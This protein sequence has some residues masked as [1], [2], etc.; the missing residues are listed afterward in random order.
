MNLYDVVS[1]NLSFILNDDETVSDF[2]R[3][4]NSEKSKKISYKEGDQKDTILFKEDKDSIPSMLLDVKSN[5]TILGVDK[6]TTNLGLDAKLS[7]VIK[8]ESLDL[9]DGTKGLVDVVNDIYEVPKSLRKSHLIVTQSSKL[10]DDF[11]NKLKLLSDDDDEKPEDIYDTTDMKFVEYDYIYNH[12]LS[13]YRRYSSTLL[14]DLLV[15]R[16][17]LKTT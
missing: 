3:K 4:F 8:K 13:S 7:E 10:S 11:D 1:N 9:H 14:R 12:L 15:N 16:K 17:L 5:R 6:M 2:M